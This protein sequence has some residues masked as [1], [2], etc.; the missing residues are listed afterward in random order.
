MTRRAN[1][2]RGS[3]FGGG[4]TFLSEGFMVTIAA[5]AL[6]MAL[7][8]GPV[9]LVGAGFAAWPLAVLV[10][11]AAFSTRFWKVLDEPL[12]RQTLGLKTAATLLVVGGVIVLRL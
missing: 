11:S 12:G 4:M 6:I 1:Q 7:S 2:G 3:F 9:S 10:L 8:V 5:L